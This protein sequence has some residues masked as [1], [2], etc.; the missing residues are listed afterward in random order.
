[1]T[2]LLK[3][4]PL[5]IK[6]FLRRSLVLTYS[7][8]TEVLVP[9]LYPG[10]ELDTFKGSGFFVVAMVQSERLRA[11]MLPRSLGTTFFLAGYRLF[12]RYRTLA[13]KN[14][15]GLQ[16]LGSETD[17][18]LM[19]RAGNVLTHYRYRLTEVEF[20]V[21]GDELNVSLRRDGRVTLDVSARLNEAVLPEESVF[22]SAKE[23][24]RFEGPMPF[25]FDYEKETNSILRVE[26]VRQAWDP[27][28]V[29]VTV[30]TPPEFADYGVPADSVQ[31]ASA[32]YLEGVPYR[33]KRGI[34][35]RLP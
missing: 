5:P 34:V 4:H 14:L 28:L 8:P 3:R 29:G 30:R 15:R 25:T 10:L 24:R 12:V 7:A 21:D 19:M 32:F 16:V 18:P 27:K 20:G 1:M 26:G 17:R 33:W 11:S 35:E 9:L 22:E 31:L 2:Y 23:A 13:G 6:T